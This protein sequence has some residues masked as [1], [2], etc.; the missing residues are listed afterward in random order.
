MPS[1]TRPGGCR[2]I[3]RSGA[4]A[5]SPPRRTRWLGSELRLSIPTDQGRWCPDTHAKPLRVSGVQ[6]GVFSGPVGSTVGQQPFVADQVVREAQP[7]WWGWTPHHGRIQ[8]RARMELSR[9]SMASVWMVGLEDSPERCGEICLFEV[10]GHAI[11]ADGST[12]DVGSG[13]HPFR[14][15]GLVEEFSADPQQIDVRE[16]H[17]YAVEWR[18]DG[19]TFLLDDRVVRTSVQSPS[20][21]MQMMIAVFDFPDAG[22]DPS[23][24]PVLAVDEVRGEALP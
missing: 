9:T 14:D 22:S 13:L 17:T 3:C 15:P 4:H 21:P 11:A 7:A 2:T 18:P 19:V 5:L 6:S 24:V 10:F 12:A 16:P 20:Y 8:V 23:H 1:S